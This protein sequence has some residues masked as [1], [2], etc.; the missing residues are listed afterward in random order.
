[1]GRSFGLSQS[2]SASESVSFENPARTTTASFRRLI[3]SAK[4]RQLIRSVTP[5]SIAAMGF[6]RDQDHR[7]ALQSFW[8]GKLPRADRHHILTSRMSPCS[9]A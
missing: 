5:M 2:P 8:S 7:S 4:R 6:S 1:M 3:G 9:H